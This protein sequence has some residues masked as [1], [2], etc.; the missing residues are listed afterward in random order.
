MI[1][2]IIVAWIVLG[3]KPSR[4]NL[5]LLTGIVAAISLVGLMI[6]IGTSETRVSADILPFYLVGLALWLALFLG[7]GFIVIWIRGG[8]VEGDA[9]KS[10]RLDKE[11]ERIRAE[12]A[13][14]DGAQPPA[15]Q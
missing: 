14:R 9:A 8:S 4:K 1:V 15:A 11:M 13:A 5:F 3:A 10:K 12:L 2:W 6:S 7:I